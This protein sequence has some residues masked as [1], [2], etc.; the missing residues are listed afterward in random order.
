MEPISIHIKKKDDKVPTKFNLYHKYR[1]VHRLV[2]KISYSD[3]IRMFKKIGGGPILTDS[4][5]AKMLLD[6]FG[7]G[8]Y[9]NIYWNKGRRGFKNFIYIEVRG[10][11]FRVIPKKKK[12]YGN[13]LREIGRLRKA[14]TTGEVK[15]KKLT[16]EEIQIAKEDIKDLK[17]EIDWDKDMEIE[18]GHIHNYLNYT[19]IRYKIHSYVQKNRN[20][21]EVDLNG[22]W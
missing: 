5:Y 21:M 11:S 2:G 22:L 12:K 19:K 6:T 4:D 13:E 17:E 9:L 16:A 3:S 10:D 20:V 18:E 1:T 7:P 15:G 8:T 14:I